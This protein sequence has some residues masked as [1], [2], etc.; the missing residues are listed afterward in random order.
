MLE[1]R[2]DEQ[3]VRII[4]AAVGRGIDRMR[5]LNLSPEVLE[6]VEGEMRAAVATAARTLRR[7]LNGGREQ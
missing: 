7:D 4:E 1:D 6:L 2:P 5:Q 3:M